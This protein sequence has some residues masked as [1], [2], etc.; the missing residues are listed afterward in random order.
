MVGL[1]GI[2]FEKNG[3]S[4]WVEKIE[5]KECLPKFGDLSKFCEI[6]S[7][8]FMWSG[9]GWVILELDT[10]ST[11]RA[12]YGSLVKSPLLVGALPEAGVFSKENLEIP[13]LIPELNFQQ[14]L[15]HLYE[16]ALAQLLEASPWLELLETNLQIQESR[17]NTVGEL[18]YLLRDL[19]SGGLVHLELAV[20][21]Y[22]AVNRGGGMVFPG[23]DARDNYHRKLARLRERQLVLT[24]K[25]RDLL[26]EKY[27]G[28]EI[29]AKQLIYGCLFDYI[30]AREPAVADFIS[31][32][33]RRGK[34]LYQ[35]ELTDDFLKGRKMSEVPK[36]LW[37]VPFEGL[38]E[39]ALEEFL[40]PVERCVMVMIA[41]DL[42]PYFVVPSGYPNS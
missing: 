12:L 42:C 25:C 1:F 10:I 32:N 31:P 24:R 38:Q 33:C 37:P 17:Q 7:V 30:N 34:W 21:F 28:E 16:D 2:Y 4:S 26:P 13:A 35:S 3:A 8:Q 29:E 39:M 15:G 5:H 22:L 6:G 23:P 19:N 14:K 27:R 9:A 40:F 11:S 20:K 18:D 41:G 36:P